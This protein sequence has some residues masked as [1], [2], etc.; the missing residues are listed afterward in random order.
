MK[1]KRKL[2]N[3]LSTALVAVAYISTAAYSSF[4]LYGET[5]IPDDLMEY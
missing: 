4:F 1:F 2:F 5:E 3:I